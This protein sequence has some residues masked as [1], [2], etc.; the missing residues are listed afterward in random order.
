MKN[1]YNHS[2]KLVLILFLILIYATSIKAQTG[3]TLKFKKD[4]PAQI[5]SYERLWDPEK[6]GTS[7]KQ[8]R[9]RS[10]FTD[11]EVEEIFGRLAKKEL[12]PESMGGGNGTTLSHYK[13]YELSYFTLF[14]FSFSLIW[15]P[16]EENLHMPKNM[17]PPTKDGSIYYTYTKNLSFNGKSASGQALAKA[18]TKVSNNTESINISS[19]DMS[20]F[21][22]S[23]T[24]STT[25]SKP[26]KISVNNV[27]QSLATQAVAEYEK[28]YVRLGE[29]DELF[30]V[31]FDK[32]KKQI[33]ADKTSNVR[34][35]LFM[36]KEHDRANA[37]LAETRKLLTDYLKKYETV[38]STNSKEKLQSW[39]KGIP[40]Y[41]TI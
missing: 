1:K 22:G 20:A 5:V 27:D 37:C 10:D 3:V 29:L 41:V 13:A 18:G 4:K 15:L 21:L 36:K 14:G 26:A 38:L 28:M 30:Q 11:Q 7:K 31:D 9:K 24:S 2:T 17:Q 33:E 39:L 35:S 19:A 34:G 23:A 32:I 40:Y 12:L 8:L 6:T 16:Y 25:T